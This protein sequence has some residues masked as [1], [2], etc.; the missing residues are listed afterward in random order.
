VLPFLEDPTTVA[1]GGY[2]A[3]AN[4]CSI[5]G[6]RVTGVALPRSWLAR[7]QTV[8]YMRSFLLFR[9]FCASQNAV[10]VVSGAF[11]LFPA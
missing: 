11:G 4:G 9:M 5:E 10:V 3:I 7:F 2:V 1:V 6:G 8:E